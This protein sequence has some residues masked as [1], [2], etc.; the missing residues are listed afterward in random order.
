MFL[1][2]KER[3]NRCEPS[4]NLPGTGN[5]KASLK[6]V[7]LPVQRPQKKALTEKDFWGEKK[8]QGGKE[9]SARE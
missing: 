7:K 6:Q 4:N 1:A 3:T 2:R 8:N 9:T 5:T